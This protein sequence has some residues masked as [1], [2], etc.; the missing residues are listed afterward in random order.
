MP[1]P[2]IPAILPFRIN[3]YFIPWMDKYTQ[4]CIQDH[5]LKDCDFRENN[6]KQSKCPA[7]EYGLIISWYIQIVKYYKT[8]KRMRRLLTRYIARCNISKLPPVYLLMH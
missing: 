3:V 1:I 2:S 6:W 4:K 7:S 8:L 5:S